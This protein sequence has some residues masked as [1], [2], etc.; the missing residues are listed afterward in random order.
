[1]QDKLLIDFA[2]YNELIFTINIS[3][4]SLLRM[5]EDRSASILVLNNIDSSLYPEM[6]NIKE[7][8]TCMIM[9]EKMLLKI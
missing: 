9:K 8:Y 4:A 3:K 5:L 6:N 7:S 1:M 2:G